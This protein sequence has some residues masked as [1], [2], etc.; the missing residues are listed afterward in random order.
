VGASLFGHGPV[1]EREVVAS[2]DRRRKVSG[3]GRRRGKDRKIK[4]ELARAK[5]P[6]VEIN[7]DAVHCLVKRRFRCPA[8]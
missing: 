1:V 2:R 5:L 4:N 7:K 8:I 6:T 3:L